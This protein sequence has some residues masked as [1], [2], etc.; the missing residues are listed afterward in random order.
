M[1]LTLE[2]EDSF[3]DAI[4][5]EFNTPNLKDALY[6]LYQSYK[7]K[8]SLEIIGQDDSDYEYILEA[9]KA[10]QNGEKLY[11]IDEVLNDL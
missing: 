6:T 10:R 9:K 1:Q 2:L 7:E 8:M 4:K 5:K 3:V 11:S